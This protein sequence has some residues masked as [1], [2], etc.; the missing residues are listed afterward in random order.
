MSKLQIGQDVAAK[1]KALAY[2]RERAW[3]AANREHVRAYA[4]AYAVRNAERLKAQ[5]GEYHRRKRLARVAERA[6]YLEAN[7]E[8]LAAE[9]RK[10]KRI[11]DARWRRNHPE[12]YRAAIAR[13]RATNPE[14]Y[15][16]LNN[17][18][19]A[20]RRSR[21]AGAGIEAVS[22]KAII[23]RDRSTCHLCRKPVAKS[24]SSI[25]HLIP[26]A[27]KGP[28]AAWNLALAHLNCNRLRRDK[29]LLLIEDRAMAEAY[30]ARLSSAGAA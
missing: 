28:W 24:D 1:R 14:K 13:S 6:A 11:K 30:V 7:R 23:A 16:L 5:R 26:V 21:V 3:V 27:R 18:K 22:I 15:R 9:R 8:T 12:A 25:D 17:E 4:K 20:R 2:A 19:A 10:R 29:R